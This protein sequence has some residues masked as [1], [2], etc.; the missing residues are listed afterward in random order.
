MPS[1]GNVKF[2]GGAGGG[3]EVRY[4]SNIAIPLI[5]YTANVGVGGE[6]SNTNVSTE[7]FWPP[8][9]VPKSIQ[10][11][12]N[13]GAQTAL[14]GGNILI[15]AEGGLGGRWRIDSYDPADYNPDRWEVGSAE[16]NRG[17]NG[18][19][20]LSIGNITGGNGGG[21]AGSNTSQ[22]QG[23]SGVT[24]GNSSNGSTGGAGGGYP[25]TASLVPFN[26]GAGVTHPLTGNLVLGG[27]GG[28]QTT[29]SLPTDSFY[30]GT[31]GGNSYGLG[32]G[33]TTTTG[34]NGVIIINIT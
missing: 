33:P 34:A 4:L 23:L 16:F 19:G 20:N 24:S 11:I 32:A 2:S 10:Y 5:T 14:S 13:S 12:A 21:V 6:T 7:G 17:G 28:A 27:G 22:P 3:G 31:P 30:T 9:S 1:G 26:G 29:G 8:G 18:G 25:T 15:T